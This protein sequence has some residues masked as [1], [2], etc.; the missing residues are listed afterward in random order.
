MDLHFWRPNLFRRGR[1]VCVFVVCLSGTPHWG[2]SQATSERLNW[3]ASAKL[4]SS[5]DGPS[6]RTCWVNLLEIFNIVVYLLSRDCSAFNHCFGLFLN[7]NYNFA[8]EELLLRNPCLFLEKLASAQF[9]VCLFVCLGLQTRQARLHCGT[10]AGVQETS[11]SSE[12][13]STGVFLLH[14]SFQ[15]WKETVPFIDPSFERPKDTWFDSLRF[16]SWIE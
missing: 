6:G 10:K 11:S 13:D 14:A 9:R 5:E 3:L 2:S 12:R 1:G 7:F 15:R 8:F 16:F 4:K